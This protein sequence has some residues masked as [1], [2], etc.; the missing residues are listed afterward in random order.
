[1]CICILGDTLYTNIQQSN[2]LVLVLLKL[3]ITPHSTII[4]LG[5]L[6]IETC[7]QKKY[8]QV[9]YLFFRYFIYVFQRES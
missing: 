1:M 4:I 6:E 2:I 5:H 7:S 8:I 3:K 9:A